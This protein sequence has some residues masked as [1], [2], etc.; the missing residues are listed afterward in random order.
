MKSIL[1]PLLLATIL[2]TI[3]A[4]QKENPIVI[5]E[6]LKLPEIS[7]EGKNTGG[8]FYNEGLLVMH[9]PIENLDNYYRYDG[10][11]GFKTVFSKMLDVT[12]ADTNIGQYFEISTLDGVGLYKNIY[13]VIYAG[14]DKPIISSKADYFKSQIHVLREDSAQKIISGLFEYEF[15]ST[16]PMI[17]NGDTVRVTNGRFD[18]KY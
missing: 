13:M 6:E 8:L 10:F 1:K 7:I 9:T 15:V 3:A 18:L 2:F 12:S 14:S 11:I 16:N 5:K 4:C 17:N